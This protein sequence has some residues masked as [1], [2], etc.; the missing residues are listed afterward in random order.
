MQ[1]AK[2][3]ENKDS[4]YKDME[5]KTIEMEN[6]EQCLVEIKSRI[7]HNY[8][9]NKLYRKSEILDLI[10]SI[11]KLKENNPNLNELNIK[12]EKMQTELE[13]IEEEL[14]E[15]MKKNGNEVEKILKE[16]ED[17]ENDC[18]AEQAEEQKSSSSN[19][20]EEA[21]ASV[22]EEEEKRPSRLREMMT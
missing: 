3:L 12:K 19:S 11:S 10:T 6:L 1:V 7:E 21:E 5:E 4:I 14:F 15:M 20:E 2:T 18:N 22:E 8:I 13:I 16:L 17:M 9:K